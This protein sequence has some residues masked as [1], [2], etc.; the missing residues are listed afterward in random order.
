VGNFSKW[1][2]VP[3]LRNENCSIDKVTGADGLDSWSDGVLC[4]CLGLMGL[5]VGPKVC[6]VF[7]TVMVV[8]Y[9]GIV[10]VQ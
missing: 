7:V 2:V 6:C 10:W 5:I 4:V 1:S 8:L 9:I 3:F